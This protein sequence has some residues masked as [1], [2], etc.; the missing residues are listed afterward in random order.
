MWVLFLEKMSWQQEGQSEGQ[1]FTIRVPWGRRVE[2][3][4]ID[5]QAGMELSGLWRQNTELCEVCGGFDMIRYCRMCRREWRRTIN[6]GW[7]EAYSG[8][9]V[10]AEGNL[11]GGYQREQR[12]EMIC[13]TTSRG[14]WGWMFYSVLVISVFYSYFWL[15]LCL[16]C[17]KTMIFLTLNMLFEC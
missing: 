11:L 7:V 9:A 12:Q 16:E 4:R 2:T 14:E 10:G 5:N 6:E 3:V 17:K 15:L 13:W 8:W 1:S